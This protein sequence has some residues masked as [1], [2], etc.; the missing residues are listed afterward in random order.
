M[1]NQLMCSSTSDALKLVNNQVKITFPTTQV[2][3]NYFAGSF[4]RNAGTLTLGTMIAQGIG[5]AV[6]PILSRIFTPEDYGLLALFSAVT[7]IT[8]TLVTLSYPIRIMLPDHNNDADKIVVLSLVLSFGIGILLLFMV[9][10]TPVGLIELIGLGKIN[11]WLP[12]AVMA[13]TATAVIGII[14]YWLNRHAQY[15]KMASLRV[16]QAV[17]NA[18]LGLLM[19]LL[20]IDDG[21]LYAQTICLLLTALF[22]VYFGSLMINP[23]S[24]RNLLYTAKIHNTAPRFIF[25]TAFTD[26]LTS[27][28]PFILITQWYA[29]ESAGYFRMAYSLLAIPGALVGGAIAQVFYQRY[30]AA[31]PDALAAKALL[32]KTWKVLTLLGIFPL[33]IILIFGKEIFSLVLGAQWSEAGMM[34]SVL[35]PM[36]FFSLVHSPT[37]TTMIT[38]GLERQVLYLSLAVLI[39]RPAALYVGF[40]YENIYLGLFLFVVLE[41][42]QMLVFQILAL[43]KLNKN[44]HKMSRA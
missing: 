37:S 38:M 32:F 36:V 12:I 6:T 2:F 27:Q 22:F 7:A 43:Q 16:V 44:I 28:L 18:C 41:I 29:A 42:I 33:L 5:I 23:Q 1:N 14:T 40:L 9:M 4:A 24:F 17:I 10:I 25:P 11:S 8:A 35:S 39:Y 21:L 19:G 20:F 13:G 3:R 30:A 31:W 15:K 34:A 26:V